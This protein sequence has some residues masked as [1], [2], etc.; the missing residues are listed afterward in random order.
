[1]STTILLTVGHNVGDVPTYTTASVA[2]A[3]A[4]VL[5]ISAFTAIPC[6]GMWRGEAEESTRLE[7]VCDSEAEAESIVALVPDLSEALQQECIMCEVRESRVSFMAPR[8][9]SSAA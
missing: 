1:M 7:V 8:T 6:Y 9:A 5:G 2:A 3:A 4:S